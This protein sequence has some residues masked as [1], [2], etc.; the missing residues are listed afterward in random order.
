MKIVDKVWGAEHWIVNNELYCA[1]KLFVKKGWQC[2]YH[3]HK[4]KD[5]TFYVETGCVLLEVGDGGHIDVG[6][7]I[8]Q[9]LKPGDIVH[10]TPGRPHRFTGIEDSI[11]LEIST[12]HDDDDV[13]RLETSR[14][15]EEQ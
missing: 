13:V 4:I 9:S 6:V 12:H 3:Y 2:S 1:K 10:L 14:Q 15:L 8:R 5:E 11:I 7:I